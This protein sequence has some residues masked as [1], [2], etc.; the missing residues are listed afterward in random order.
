MTDVMPMVMAKHPIIKRE[1]NECS[2]PQCNQH[3]GHI[4]V[5]HNRYSYL[6][7]VYASSKRL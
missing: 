7:G 5:T 6:L 3:F 2:Y 4:K 1:P